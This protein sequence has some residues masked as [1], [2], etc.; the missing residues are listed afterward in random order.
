MRVMF[1]DA[2]AQRVDMLEMKAMRPL[3]LYI[4]TTYKNYASGFDY[5]GFKVSR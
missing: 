3:K 4:K 2:R 1:S 5:H